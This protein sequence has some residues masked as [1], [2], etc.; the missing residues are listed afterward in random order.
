MVTSGYFHGGFHI[1]LS[2]GGDSLKLY[3]FIRGGNFF[4]PMLS[5]EVN[6]HKRIISLF[7]RL[8]PVDMADIYFPLGKEG[9][10]VHIILPLAPPGDL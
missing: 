9:D 6:P 8:L 5:V 2:G 4:P 10:I 1:E 3:S 7:P